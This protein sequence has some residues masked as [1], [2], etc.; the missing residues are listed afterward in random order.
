MNLYVI[1]NIDKNKYV[2][3][4]G[5]EFSFTDRLEAAR[6]FPSYEAARD[7]CCENEHPISVASLLRDP[8]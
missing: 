2:A 7:K 8:K 1:R 3:P 6:T 4:S 5:E